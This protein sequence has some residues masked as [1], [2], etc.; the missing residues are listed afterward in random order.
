MD[1]GL[2]G[3]VA[4]VPASSR[5]LGRAC[6]HAL[7][8][9]G[10]RMM[11]SSRSDEAAE[12]T[13]SELREDTGAEV[14]ACAADVTSLEALERLVATTNE[15]LGPIDVLVTNTGPPAAGRL[16]EL[17]DADWIEAFELVTLSVLR[18]IRLVVPSMRERG[19]GRVVAIQSTSVRQPIPHLVLSNGIRPG[20]AGALK[21]LADV[22]AADGVTVNTVL[23]GVFRTDRLLGDLEE[24]GGSVEDQIAAIASRN[25]SGRVGD[26]PELGAVVAFLASERASFINGVA[27]QVDGGAVRAIA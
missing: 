27:L 24:S 1:L 16:D 12:A 20:V 6:A 19:W 17:S 10:A 2:T 18:L 4:L 26:P 23:P 5:G 22:A 21:S 15:R 13:A 8:R 7:A 25:P 3:K 14:L 11:V 9:E